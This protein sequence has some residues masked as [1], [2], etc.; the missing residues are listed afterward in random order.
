MAQRFQRVHSGH[1]LRVLVV[2]DQPFML[3]ALAVLL[4]DEDWLDLVG[5]APGPIEAVALAERLQPDVAILD[6]AMGGGGAPAAARGLARC[7]P[8]TRTIAFTGSFDGPAL[9]DMIRS[10]TAGY[11]AKTARA[12]ELLDIVRQAGAAPSP[13]NGDRAG[14]AFPG[15]DRPVR[16]LIAHPEPTVVSALSSLLDEDCSAQVVGTA[17]DAAAALLSARS[18]NPDVALVDA[19]MPVVAEGGLV[20]EFARRFPALPVAAPHLISDH[21]FVQRLLTA[22]ST[23]CLFPVAS[24]TVIRDTLRRALQD[25]APPAL[26]TPSHPLIVC[27]GARTLLPRPTAASVAT[28]G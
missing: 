6:V 18:A 21:S 7:S 10:G 16:L 26:G 23:T 4:Q 27:A 3:E 17:T 24:G 13:P 1:R 15:A 25:P 9:L 14:P 12:W 2:D 19:R 5:T 8:G 11:A 20:G 28:R 22:G